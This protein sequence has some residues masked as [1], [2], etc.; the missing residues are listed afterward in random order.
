MLKDDLL[1]IWGTNGTQLPRKFFSYGSIFKHF[2]TRT[3]NHSSLSLTKLRKFLKE[4]FFRVNF[5]LKHCKKS[6]ANK[7]KKERLREI[8]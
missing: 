4:S 7:W 2:E 8:G 1:Y 3:E 5:R 6:P